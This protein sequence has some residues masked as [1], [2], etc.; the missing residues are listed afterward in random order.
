MNSSLLKGIRFKQD[1]TGQLI[2]SNK[3]HLSKI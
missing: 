2:K 1:I 3:V